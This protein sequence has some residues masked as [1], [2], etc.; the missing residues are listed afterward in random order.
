M[1]CANIFSSPYSCCLLY[2][3]P[4]LIRSRRESFAK[5]LYMKSLTREKLVFGHPVPTAVLAI[6]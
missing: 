1:K 2:G 5:K 3:M 6:V 4:P